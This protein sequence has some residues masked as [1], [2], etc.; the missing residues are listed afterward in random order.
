MRSDTRYFD[1]G[2]EVDPRPNIGANWRNC[3]RLLNW[4]DVELGGLCVFIGCP[5]TGE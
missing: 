4:S 2:P 1:S 3:M 5:R